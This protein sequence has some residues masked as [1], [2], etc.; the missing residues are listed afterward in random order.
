MPYNFFTDIFVRPYVFYFNALDLM[1]NNTSELDG[2]MSRMPPVYEMSFASF[3]ELIF[4]H[5]WSWTIT[6]K[7]ASA[8]RMEWLSSVW[9]STKAG[10]FFDIYWKNPRLRQQLP[11]SA[12]KYRFT[13]S[14][15]NPITKSIGLDPACHSDNV[16]I[17]EL[18]AASCAWVAAVQAHC[19]AAATTG[20]R[21][22]RR[23]E[24]IDDYLLLTSLWLAHPW[25]Q[26]R[27]RRRTEEKARQ[28]REEAECPLP[29]PELS[30]DPYW[31]SAKVIHAQAPT[32]SPE[33]ERLRN[34]E[35]KTIAFWLDRYRSEN[36]QWTSEFDFYIWH[37]REDMDIARG[38]ILE[39][40]EII[41]QQRLFTVHARKVIDKNQ[42]EE[43]KLRGKVPRGRP[44]PTA[45][46]QE[47]MARFTS[48][49][50]RSLMALFGTESCAQLETVVQGSNQR[51]WRRWL[52]GEAIPNTTT[53]AKLQAATVLRGQWKGRP[54]RTL[55]TMPSHD[56]LLALIRLAGVVVTIR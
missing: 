32:L 19:A 44:K 31:P 16:L 52:K 42:R 20:G 45:D 3:A 12:Q 7:L 14:E 54:L 4:P 35:R 13:D 48:Q 6:P 1:D 56:D 26:G 34:E 46:R 21:Y 47:T 43:A 53:L 9:D 2:I 8:N 39:L 24:V 25:I 15:V 18:W 22:S 51:N 49:W 28:A 41:E 33:E 10:S 29:P 30:D 27:I 40:E 23:A 36:S 50:V 38:K 55:P 5:T 11:S 17:A 37:A